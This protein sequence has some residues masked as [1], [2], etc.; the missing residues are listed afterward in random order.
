MIDIGDERTT[1]QSA[2]GVLSTDTG[3]FGRGDIGLDGRLQCQPGGTGC[4]GISEIDGGINTT[5]RSDSRT[6]CRVLLTCQN[7]CVACRD[8]SISRVDGLKWNDSDCTHAD[9]HAAIGDNSGSLYGTQKGIACDS[10]ERSNQNITVVSSQPPGQRQ[11][12]GR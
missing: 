4:D 9:T 10:Y 12:T 5:V 3:R 2:V 8:Q 1:L 6:K 11:A 7:T